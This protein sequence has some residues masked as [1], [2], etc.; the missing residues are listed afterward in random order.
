[1]RGVLIS[2]AFVLSFLTPYHVL[3]AADPLV[4]EKEPLLRLEAGGPTAQVT[5]MALSLNGE[6]LYIAGLDKV[7][8]VWSRDAKEQR[9]E[10]VNSYRVPVGPGMEGALNA[11]AVSADG[12]WLAT[13]G[14]GARRMTSGFREQGLVWL[15][16]PAANS[17]EMQQ[18]QGTIY[19]FN[20]VDG[21]VRRLRGHAGS[22]W[23]LKFVQGADAPYLVS[24]A[25]TWD[26][27]SKRYVVDLRL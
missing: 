16:S 18:D 9:F 19:V 15:P 24:A 12:K 25:K 23:S 11:V 6:S 13:G 22:I 5:S 2:F 8:R 7:V 20:T 3:A 26:A 10:L 14:S 21:T 27:R 17:I 1:M 4:G